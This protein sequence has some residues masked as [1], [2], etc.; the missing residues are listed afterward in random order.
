MDGTHTPRCSPSPRSRCITRYVRPGPSSR[1]SISIDDLRR[2]AALEKL[3]E[4]RLAK[5]RHPRSSP[6]GP[7]WAHLS[8][9]E[10]IAV[11]IYPGRCSPSSPVRQSR[12]QDKISASVQNTAG[13]PWITEDGPAGYGHTWTMRKRCRRPASS[14]QSTKAAT[15]R[16][17]S[18][19]QD[20]PG[21]RLLPGRGQFTRPA[22]AS[23]CSGAT[24]QWKDGKPMNRSINAACDGASQA[25]RRAQRPT[26]FLRSRC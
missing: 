19:P 25:G 24:V 11:L 18:R 15:R 13:E 9:Q 2:Q 23:M 26:F 20:R 7:T 5:G 12:C 4:F 14:L 6:T 10:R 1:R 3:Y 8:A 22:A 17:R 21:G 16:C